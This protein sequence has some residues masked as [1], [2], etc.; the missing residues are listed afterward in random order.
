VGPAGA[1]AIATFVVP[2]ADVAAES[3]KTV[4]EVE[5]TNRTEEGGADKVVAAVDELVEPR[6]G[7]T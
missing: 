3:G 2:V 7:C 4:A 1:E 6:F 5:G